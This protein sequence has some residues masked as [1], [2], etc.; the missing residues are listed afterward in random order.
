MTMRIFLFEPSNI[1]RHSI[2]H[3]LV[4]QNF[5]VHTFS[6]CSEALE[7][8][9]G[10]YQCF[11]IGFSV[12]HPEEG[13][14]LL[15]SIRL[16]YP[17]IPVLMMNFHD[18]TDISVLRKAYSY[19][20]DDVLKKPFLIEEIDK[21]IVRLLHIRRNIV[22]FGEYGMFDFDAGILTCGH[23]HKH[24]SKNERRL[25]SLLY[26]YKEN[27]VSFEMIQNMVWEGESV[28][29]ESVR[30]LVRRVRKKLPFMCIMTMPNVGYALRL[31][32]YFQ[33]IEAIA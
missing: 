12:E 18:R 9:D 1:L 31:N 33:H 21:K 10:G 4:S 25:L 30:S 20:C 26:S 19:G 24:F 6:F 28:T 29:I 11:I 17:E 5:I 16:C 15:K 3:Y 7:A 27:I 32:H 22:R 13:L 14:E 23:F 2:K 8:I